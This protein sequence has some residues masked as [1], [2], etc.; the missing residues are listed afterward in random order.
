MSYETNWLVK[1]ITWVRAEIT[2]SLFIMYILFNQLTGMDNNDLK[3]SQRC[4]VAAVSNKMYDAISLR[5]E[6]EDMYFEM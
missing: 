3:M 2:F 4:L 5:R 1:S 6:T